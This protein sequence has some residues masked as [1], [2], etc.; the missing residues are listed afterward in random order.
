MDDVRA[1]VPRRQAGEPDIVSRVHLAEALRRKGYAKNR[2]EAFEKYV[3]QGAAAYVEKE[4]LSPGRAIAAI[5]DA[6]GMALLAHPVQLRCENR[7]QLERALREL[8]DAGL[9]GIEAYHS[10]HTPRQTRQCL[11]LAKQYGLVVSGGS[12]YHGAGKPEVRLGHPRAPV[13][14]V[15]EQQLQAWAR[16]P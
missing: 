9:G 10:D 13:S 4:R 5:T 14:V 8:M 7:A 12:D 6:G 11:D 3:G 16:V 1:C 2:H 15:G